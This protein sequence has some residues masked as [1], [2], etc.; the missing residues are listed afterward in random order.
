[1]QPVLQHLQQYQYQWPALQQHSQNLHGAW[2]QPHG[3]ADIAPAQHI[4]MTPGAMPN[5]TQ[6]QMPMQTTTLNKEL[7]EYMDFKQQ[8]RQSYVADGMGMFKLE[9]TQHSPTPGHMPMPYKQEDMVNAMYGYGCNTVNQQDSMMYGQPFQQDSTMYGQPYQQ[10]STMYGQ[11][12]QQDS[13][14]YSQPSQQ[15]NTRYS[16]YVMNNM[17][18]N[19]DM[20]YDQYL[21]RHL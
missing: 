21:P 9:E 19:K 6:V 15:D 3:Q 5:M 20:L 18:I 16:K 4:D 8:I 13:T 7:G 10:E 1:M 12:Y 14:M 17:M 11:A 2:A